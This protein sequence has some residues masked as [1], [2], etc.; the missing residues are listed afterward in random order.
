MKWLA[1]TIGLLAMSGSLIVWIYFH[2][3]DASRPFAPERS[4]AHADAVSAGN[5][6]GLACG[7]ERC[8]VAVL[9]S[10]R[11]HVWLTRIADGSRARCFE[12]DLYT[13]SMH[14]HHGPSGVRAV[15]CRSER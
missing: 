14:E 10:P 12:I 15:A 9:T 8:T 1:V 7:Q 5:V 2:D 13:F 4:L 3:R 6:G 11:P